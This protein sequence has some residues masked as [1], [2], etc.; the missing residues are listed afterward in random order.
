M[1]LNREIENKLLNAADVA[2]IIEICKSAG[3]EVSEAEAQQLL[4][5][6]ADK[7]W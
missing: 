4:D 5:K 2:E 1:K 6:A 7:K 3:L